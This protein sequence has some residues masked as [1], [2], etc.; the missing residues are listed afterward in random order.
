[1]SSEALRDALVELGWS[2]FTELGVPGVVRHHQGIALDPE[3]IVVAAPSLFELDPRLRDQVYGWCASHAARLSVSRLQGLSRDL[4][5]P[6]QRAFHGLAAT[7][8]AHAKV[9][10]PDDG[11]PSWVRA[12]EVKARRLPLE[13][14]ALLRFRARA[15]CGV[16]G[17][18][19]VVSELIARSGVWTR[20]SA[21][22][23][24]GYSKRAMAGILSEL[25]EAGVARQVA[26]RNALTFQL[27]RP[28]QLR[29]LL[30]ADDVS[31]PSWRRI[32]SAVLRLLDLA[33]LDESSAAV[34]RVEANK[35]REAFCGLAESIWLETPPVTRGNPN[36]WEELTAWAVQHA[37][38]LASGSAPVFTGLKAYEVDGSHEAW[39][40]LH[41]SAPRFGQLA[42]RL[43]EPQRSI[44]G[45]KRTAAS[46]AS[47]GWTTFQ[48]MSPARVD[49]RP[50]V[51][52]LLASTKLAWRKAR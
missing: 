52:E 42:A 3:P 23:E 35:C 39:V 8:R 15:L 19:D 22:I 37:L 24:L 12:P 25:T 43:T 26:D 5:E 4:P 29:D 6:A 47:G 27:S 16:G 40:W 31:H 18:A 14:P 2:L 51:D 34:R 7:L 1:M 44:S 28:E 17:R 33:G 21:L 38:E 30:Q 13:R 10:W 45:L 20:A 41:R 50:R 49:I 48:L 36:A 11:E 32:M 46:P 9:R